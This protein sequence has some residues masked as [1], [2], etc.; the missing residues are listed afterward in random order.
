[1]ENNKIVHEVDG[2]KFTDELLALVESV[3][4]EKPKRSDLQKLKR[5]LDE[6]PG[7]WRA[8]FDITEMI[9]KNTIKRMVSQKAMQLSL[10]A[11]IS[12]MRQNLGYLNSSA[13]EQL[14]IEN[15]ISTWLN[16]KWADYQVV[17]FMG[18]AG[19]RFKEIEFWERRLSM[20]QRRYLQACESLAKVRRLMARTPAVQVNIASQGGQQV[21]VA[22]DVVK[23]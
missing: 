20:S 17:T 9:Q 11:N 5:F 22:G 18:K 3:Y 4:V 23:K 16:Y 8:I 13:L 7:L 2:S 19:V 6:T 1:M 10:E 14:L 15:I 21:N 12:E